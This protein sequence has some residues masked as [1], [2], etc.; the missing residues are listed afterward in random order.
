MVQDG[1]IRVLNLIDL[2]SKEKGSFSDVVDVLLYDL[3]YQ[4]NIDEK[5]ILEKAKWSFQA[6]LIPQ[7]HGNVTNGQ[8]VVQNGKDLN[9]GLRYEDIST[10]SDEE[11]NE[12]EDDTNNGTL[13][14]YEEVELDDIVD[15]LITSTELIT[16]QAAINIIFNHYFPNFIIAS[17]D[18]VISLLP[19][20][21]EHLTNIA[22]DEAG[23]S[24]T[25]DIVAMVTESKKLEQLVLIG[26]TSQYPS[27]QRLPIKDSIPNCF[28]NVMRR[29]NLKSQNL[30]LILL[31]KTF[32]LNPGLA[33]VMKTLFY[34]NRDISSLLQRKPLASGIFGN[35][36]IPLMFVDMDGNDLS[37]YPTT[38][39]NPQHTFAALNAVKRV[40]E[41]DNSLKITVLC[42]YDGQ[43]IH[44]LRALKRYKL[45]K[46]VEVS[47]VDSFYGKTTDVAIIVTTR[48]LDE[49]NHPRRYVPVF[50]N[51]KLF[52]QR[53][54]V[55]MNETSE[56][57]DDSCFYSF[58]FDE[59]R[60][61][62]AISRGEKATIIIGSAE[63][64]RENEKWNVLL[65]LAVTNSNFVKEPPQP[66]ETIAVSKLKRK[67][68][69]HRRERFPPEGAPQAKHRRIVTE[70]R[71][72]QEEI[73]FEESR[74][75]LAPDNQQI[76]HGQKRKRNRR[77]KR[78][79]QGVAVQE[80]YE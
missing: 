25:L 66:L 72:S 55:P 33:M 77:R 30:I 18:T 24:S 73:Q 19:S 14:S 41:A 63:L 23:H 12:G 58:V 38:R 16:L 68:Q 10:A 28:D 2:D 62:T 61:L 27:H 54:P 40:I 53:I 51:E 36:E 7:Y 52:L 57:G 78:N 49:R 26:D 42:Y 5:E 50:K 70:Q 69:Q 59:Q 31:N 76:H 17:N 56:L 1:D 64:L 11:E 4:L 35:P 48:N 39:Y 29:I 65:N 47:T 8:Q 15:D 80:M 71:P 74:Q 21:G 46:I 44:M 45:D 22:V 13:S 67:K 34:P 60:L 20:L 3:K 37:V 9:D 6:K 32:N 75:P 43:R 79:Q